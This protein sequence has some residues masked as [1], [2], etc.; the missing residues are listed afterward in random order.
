MSALD[1]VN[2]EDQDHQGYQNRPEPCGVLMEDGTPCVEQGEIK[3]GITWVCPDHWEAAV[4][5]GQERTFVG[6]WEAPYSPG[7]V[8]RPSGLFEEW[9]MRYVTDS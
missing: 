5:A 9:R 6:E 1:L 7:L 8:E 4:D 3:L 2:A